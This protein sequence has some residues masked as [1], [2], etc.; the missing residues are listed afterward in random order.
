MLG[1]SDLNANADVLRHDLKTLPAVFGAVNRSHAQVSARVDAVSDL[2]KRSED[3]VEFAVRQLLHI[4]YDTR[5]E[6]HT[7]G[8]H[9]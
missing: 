8:V 2:V 9:F 3:S 5:M 6:K 1:V 7:P 4:T